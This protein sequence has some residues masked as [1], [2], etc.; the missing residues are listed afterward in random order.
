M[1]S[2]NIICI[3]RRL[4]TFRGAICYSYG[5]L[6]KPL[7]S[8]NI[9]LDR[10]TVVKSRL[11]LFPKRCSLIFDTS[12]RFDYRFYTTNKTNVVAEPKDEW[13]TLSFYSFNLNVQLSLK[14]LRESMLS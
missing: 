6:T 12:G 10:L 5:P 7:C 1:F 9:P 3:F 14:K 2:M 4:Q 13:M 11:N 8:K